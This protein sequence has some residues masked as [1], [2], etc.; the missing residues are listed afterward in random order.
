MNINEKL[1][2]K[3]Q[4]YQTIFNL[5]KKRLP[6]IER[7]TKLI[8]EENSRLKAENDRLPKESNSLTAE[9]NKLNAENASLTEE[10]SQLEQQIE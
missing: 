10:K 7:K 3:L 8:V 5:L 4:K 9:N 2:Q 6:D 1:L